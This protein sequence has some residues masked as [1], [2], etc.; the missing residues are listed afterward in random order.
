LYAIFG[1]RQK[2][3]IEIDSTSLPCPMDRYPKAVCF[4]NTSCEDCKGFHLKELIKASPK[5][6]YNNWQHGSLIQ[7]IRFWIAELIRPKLPKINNYG[8]W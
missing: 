1:E 8:I 7:R 2:T 3:M 5:T 6:A 4:G